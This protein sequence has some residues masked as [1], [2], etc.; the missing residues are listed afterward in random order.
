MGRDNRMRLKQ[1]EIE[2]IKQWRETGT[3]PQGHL[4]SSDTNVIKLKKKFTDLEGRYKS[5]LD[6]YS[7]SQEQNDIYD[8]LKNK[9]INKFKINPLNKDKVGEATAIMVASDWHIEENIDPLT[10]NGKN[11]FNPK[12]AKER[13]TKFFQKGLFLTNLIRNGINID[14][15][16]LALL[17]DLISGYI[18][19]ELMENNYLSP[20]QAILYTQELLISGIDFLIKEGKFKRIIVPCCFGNHGR[21]TEKKKVS[22]SYK[23]SFEWLLYHNL[24]KYYENNKNI[25]FIV[26]N[27]YHTYLNLYNKYTLRFHHGDNIKYG[28][29]IG[30]ITIPVNKAIKQWNSTEQAYLDVFGHFHQQS[31]GGKFISNGSLCGFNDYALAIKAEYEQPQQ[32]FFVMDK[33]RGK[34]IVA[35]IFLD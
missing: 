2:L 19:E 34:V 14:T 27:G 7:N 18:H 29:G 24:K 3:V 20:T 6:E 15:L 35:P 4:I 12:I 23:N 32:S 25:T 13:V 28:G 10:I 1:D 21:T 16:V 11:E 33:E 22:T 26:E 9:S 30:G 31:D 17:G 5:L 8:S